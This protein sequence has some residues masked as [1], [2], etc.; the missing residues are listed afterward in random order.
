MKFVDEGSSGLVL[1]ISVPV[2]L[3]AAVR[4]VSRTSHSPRSLVAAVSARAANPNPRGTVA[5]S[6]VLAAPVIVLSDCRGNLVRLED[7][8]KGFNGAALP[9]RERI[10]QAARAGFSPLP[11][12]H[13]TVKYKSYMAGVLVAD[14][15]AALAAEAGT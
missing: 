14:L 3:L 7:A 2:G 9:G 12:L 6:P 8:E 4:A 11:D 5:P 1:G 13:A 10:E 15:L